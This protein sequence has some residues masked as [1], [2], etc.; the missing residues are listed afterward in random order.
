MQISENLTIIETAIKAPSFDTLQ[1]VIAEIPMSGTTYV[2][3]A[4][5]S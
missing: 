5:A 2:A 4:G 3:K 1:M